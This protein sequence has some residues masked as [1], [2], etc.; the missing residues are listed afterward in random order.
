MHRR[1]LQRRLTVA[2]TLLNRQN[3]EALNQN[4]GTRSM[5]SNHR[6]FV[7]ASVR[8]GN[9]EQAGWESNAASPINRHDIAEMENM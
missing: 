4:E 5:K 7:V 1:I 2:E 3:G 8:S 6:Q 9:K